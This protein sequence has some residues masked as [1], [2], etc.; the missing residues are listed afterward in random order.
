MIIEERLISINESTRSGEKI[1]NI[2][3]VIL[4]GISGYSTVSVRNSIENMHKISDMYISY[5]YLIGNDGKIIRC[6]PEDEVSYA[7]YSIDAN[8][9]SVSIA[10][11]ENGESI[12]KD[13]IEN[14]C[15]LIN[16]IC[17]KYNLD[18]LNDVIMEYDVS[19]KR[20]PRTFI[21]NRAIY[22]NIIKY[23]K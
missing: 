22:N 16:Y 12:K 5:H 15:L 13:T 1:H 7:T 20:S 14:L 21:D 4:C 6:I 11:I 17:N 19:L 3:K 2:N 18:I 8:L 23:K 9:N 10:I